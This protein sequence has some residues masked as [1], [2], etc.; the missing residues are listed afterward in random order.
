VQITQSTTTVP[1]IGPIA[2]DRGFRSVTRMIGLDHVL[3]RLR[4]P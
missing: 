4:L 3:K 1:V 2:H